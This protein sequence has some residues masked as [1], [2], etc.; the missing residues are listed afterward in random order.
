[1]SGGVTRVSPTS[2]LV[3]PQAAPDTKAA[4]LKSAAGDFESLLIKQLLKEAKVTG[5]DKSNGYG[6][7][8]IDALASSIE[9]GGGLGLAKHIE[10][11]IGSSGAAS[12]AHPVQGAVP[13]AGTPAVAA[14]VLPVGVSAPSVGGQ[15][16]RSR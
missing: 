12:A 16:K 11:A 5:S 10:K 2:S 6:D 13:V 7:M 3:A 14:S 4:K 8:A 1:M 15:P 9:R